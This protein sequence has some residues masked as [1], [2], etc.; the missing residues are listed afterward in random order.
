MSDQSDETYAERWAEA[1]NETYEAD[2]DEV[3]LP[4]T[5]QH[6]ETADDAVERVLRKAAECLRDGKAHTFTGQELDIVR[7]FM[8][9]HEVHQSGSVRWVLDKYGPPKQR[10][11]GNR[12]W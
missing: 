5:P 9:A 12:I 2:P 3:V 10:G 8:P 11:H 1:I 7:I 4:G 6:G